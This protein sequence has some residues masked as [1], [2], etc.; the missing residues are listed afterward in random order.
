MRTRIADRIASGV[1]EN[2]AVVSGNTV[3]LSGN[4]SVPLG[5]PGADGRCLPPHRRTSHRP[6]SLPRLMEG[7]HV[8]CN[9]P[10]AAAGVSTAGWFRAAQ[11]KTKQRLLQTVLRPPA[12]SATGSFPRLA[13]G[14]T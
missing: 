9:C 10:Q 3:E 5:T 6:T 14:T 12:G 13:G 8:R 1:A 11:R 7:Q 2:I 4:L